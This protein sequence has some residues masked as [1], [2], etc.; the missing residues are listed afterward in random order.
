[1]PTSHNELRK[2]LLA[3]IR[4][5]QR[6]DPAASGNSFKPVGGQ[7][8]RFRAT[9][10]ELDPEWSQSID[11]KDG[12]SVREFEGLSLAARAAIVKSTATDGKLDK[13]SARSD[14]STVL[15]SL[16]RDAC[17]TEP[18][19]TIA[20]EV[21]EDVLAKFDIPGSTPDGGLPRGRSLQIVGCRIGTTER[22]LRLANIQ[23]PLALSFVGCVFEGGII[24]KDSELR[25][26]DLS[27]SALT[28]L[29]ASGLRLQGSLSMARSTVIA[30]MALAGAQIG[31]DLDLSDLLA[32][33]VGA[34]CPE[35]SIAPD[36]GM[37]DLSRIIVGNEAT[38][39]R[40]RI[41]G[42]FSLRGAEFQRSVFARG[43]TLVS[44]LG[45]LEQWSRDEQRK[46]HPRGAKVDSTPPDENARTGRP[47]V[48]ARVLHRGPWDANSTSAGDDSDHREDRT[49]NEGLAQPEKRIGSLDAR[50]KLE[51][52]DEFTAWDAPPVKI[53]TEHSQRQ[54][55]HAVRADLM[56]VAGSLF[57]EES[58]VSGVFRAK[59]ARIGGSLRL[60]SIA[61]YAPS[62]LG[63]MKF[64]RR[65]EVLQK[66]PKAEL[67][68]RALDLT[69]ATIEGDVSTVVG[70]HAAALPTPI[71]SPPD[72]T[73]DDEAQTSTGNSASTKS[74][75]SGDDGDARLECHGRLQLKG[76]KIG[77]TL[78]LRGMKTVW[79]PPGVDPDACA[80]ISVGQST[81]PPSEQGDEEAKLARRRSALEKAVLNLDQAKIGDDVDLR[82][83]RGLWGVKLQNANIGGSVYFSSKSSGRRAQL[84]DNQANERADRR[85]PQ[86]TARPVNDPLHESECGGRSGGQRVDDH[87]NSDVKERLC[88]RPEQ[89]ESKSKSASGTA[90]NRHKK[91]NRF[92]IICEFRAYDVRGRVNLRGCKVAGDVHLLFD[93]D[94]GP[95]LKLEQAQIAGRLDIYPQRRRPTTQQG[96]DG[97]QRVDSPARP[98][99]DSLGDDSTFAI[100][101]PGP[102]TKLKD[103]YDND[104]W[105]I[106]L[107]NARAT[108]FSH[109]PGA[110]PHPGYLSLDG[111]RYQA[112]GAIGPLAPLP[113]TSVV[114]KGSI[115]A[116]QPTVM[117]N[118]F[119]G[120]AVAFFAALLL[121]KHLHISLLTS[122]LC[123]LL[124]AWI[125]VPSIA[126]R[127]LLPK[128]GQNLPLALSYLARQ[129][130]EHTRYQNIPTLYVPLEPY[131]VA[132]KAMREGGR[133]V[134]ANLV[135]VDRLKRRVEMLSFRIH[136]ATRPLLG[137]AFAV[138]KFGFSTE[139]MAMLFVILVVALTMSLTYLG[140]YDQIEPVRP[141]EVG[142]SQLN[143]PRDR[144]PME[145]L[146]DCPGMALAIDLLTPMDLRQIDLWTSAGDHKRRVDLFLLAARVAGVLFFLI[147]GTALIARLESVFSRGRE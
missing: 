53:L 84:R 20:A 90:E 140:K 121:S 49:E 3:A 143:C 5:G 9:A 36:R 91:G 48:V 59:Y 147:L 105:A 1:M 6:I 122:L 63:G 74:S 128:K 27:G 86:D 136:G 82:R 77:G 61:L 43:C 66:L 46:S 23:I 54:L 69:Q 96:G 133:Y 94:V 118:H 29:D 97:G 98:I 106:D 68:T 119:A 99:D 130:T 34:F 70:G 22:P 85:C 114:A 10:F 67:E 76:V 131:D 33:P 42:G 75:Q 117:M 100:E 7:L 72:P 32:A 44:P 126:S 71:Q 101:D 52:L 30:P 41:W 81:P 134:S 51:V 21:I 26:L 79:S 145:F 73:T 89:D 4:Q 102:P 65:Q 11:R 64:P 62:S 111:F 83:S 127:L 40:A 47:D 80:Y 78:H 138:S 115:L 124:V 141:P 60:G 112:V 37:V 19:K 146:D 88:H 132:A 50:R 108:V 14:Y 120:L 103:P 39:D 116:R 109:A 12:L 110:W 28:Q 25:S 137:V 142:S 113:P 24:L 123:C 18:K 35:I 95:E 38:F 17:L 13:N 58:L 31:G 135:E 55:T 92:E 139:R 57:L 56:T 93:P 104:H 129:R 107:R 45:L 8:P 16:L 144:R 2:P 15:D 87:P 125:V